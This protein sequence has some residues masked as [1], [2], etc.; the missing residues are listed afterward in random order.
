M[1]RDAQPD[2]PDPM[3]IDPNRLDREWLSQAQLTRR[4]GYSEADARHLYNQAKA[5]LDVVEA[6]LKLAVG[7]NPSEY[8]LKDKPTV[9]EIAAAVV[10]Q[11]Q[12]QDAEDA[13]RLAAYEL[14]VRKADSTACLDRRKALE[15]LVELLALDYHAER[16]EPAPKTEAG[17]AAAARMRDRAIGGLPAADVE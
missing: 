10:V 4:T 12:Y 17:R 1:P 16:G 9:A 6:R 2:P 11:K 14:D 3:G 5:T 15:R 7:R 13:V 8:N